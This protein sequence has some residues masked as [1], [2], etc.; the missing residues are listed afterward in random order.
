MLKSFIFQVLYGLTPR[1]SRFIR[2]C[3]KKRVTWFKT[4]T[5]L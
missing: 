1:M 3:R 5:I 4:I 2:T